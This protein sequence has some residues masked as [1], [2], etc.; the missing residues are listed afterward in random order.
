MQTFD[1][2]NQVLSSAVAAS[3]TFTVTYPANRQIGNYQLGIDHSI[4]WN[5]QL[6]K[7]PEDFTL[8]F[9]ATSAT[10]TLGSA[11]SFPAGANIFTQLNHSGA[12]SPS[13]S[14]D[15]Q[16]LSA[17]AQAA[18]VD[19]SEANMALI[20][21]GSPAAGDLVGVAA[22][23]TLATGGALALTTAAGVTTP[24]PRAVQFAGTSTIDLSALTLDVTGTDLYGVA[25]SENLLGPN[26][27]ATV[28]GKKAFASVTSAVLTTGTASAGAGIKIGFSNVLGLPL[29]LK[30]TGLVLRELADGATPS[31]GTIVAADQATPTATT[32]DVRGTWAPNTTPNGTVSFALVVAVPKPSTGPVQ[33]TG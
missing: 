14:E 8:S 1:V 13:F 10:V 11:V 2:I 17:K 18:R 4:A 7:F 15:L 30:K 32:G 6:L 26:G 25:M 5:G 22:L 19:I 29:V 12:A 24:V 28:S 31:A 3:G 27:A 33:F 16:R 21:L 20:E 9:G 23:Q